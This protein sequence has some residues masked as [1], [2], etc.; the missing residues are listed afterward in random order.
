MAAV[1]ALVTGPI[2]DRWGARVVLRFSFAIMALG[3]VAGAVA[4]TEWTIMLAA[5]FLMGAIAVPIN[6]AVQAYLVNLLPNNRRRALSL[7]L[8]A[9]ATMG[10]ICPLIAE[11]FLLLVARGRTSFAGVLH[12][13]MA[14]I[15]VVMLLGTWFLRRRG[16]AA[17]GPAGPR[18]A[19]RWGRGMFSGGIVGPL[20]LVVLHGVCD[21]GSSYWIPRLLNSDSFATHPVGGG[22]VI[23]G[24]MAGYALS[25]GLLALFPENAGRRWTLIAPGP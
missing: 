1:L 15:A 5:M 10:V 8:A 19:V 2:I 22:V 7:N 14:L 12:I 24:F 11:G 4:G 3:M 9:N 16:T 23:A 6:M 17:N 21:N 13:P 25:R 20:M 18:R